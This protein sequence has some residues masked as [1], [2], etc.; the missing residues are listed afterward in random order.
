MHPT[1][2]CDNIKLQN[3]NHYGAITEDEK[4]DL[5]NRLR[6]THPRNFLASDMFMTIVELNISYDSHHGNRKTATKISIQKLNLYSA[7]DAEYQAQ[8]QAEADI[9]KY[10]VIH[11]ESALKN[12]KIESVKILGFATLRIE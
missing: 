12:Y 9:E 8:I 4:T 5:L 7:D 6:N 3:G 2:F 10:N 1:V 11:K